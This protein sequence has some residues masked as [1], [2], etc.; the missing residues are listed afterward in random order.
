MHIFWHNNSTSKNFEKQKCKDMA[1]DTL[2]GVARIS[3][4]AREK[5]Q[6]KK[7]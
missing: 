6:G 3:K 5:R 7:L 4:K 2:F 1:K